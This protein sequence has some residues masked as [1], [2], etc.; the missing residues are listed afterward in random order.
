MLQLSLLA[1]LEKVKM[2]S[3]YNL[4]WN[5][6]H[7]ETFRSFETLR[8]REMFVDVTLS[9][10]DQFLKA[11][12]LVLCAGSGYFERILNRDASG[13]PL[14]HFYGIDM[15]LLKLLVEFMYNGEVEVPS[16]DLEK[17]IE[18]AEHL[19]VKG[20]KGD[21]SKGSSV[22]HGMGG[23]TI[24]VAGVEDA[25]AHKRKSSARSWQDYDESLTPPVKLARPLVHPARQQWVGHTPSHQRAKP[26]NVSCS[27]A[28]C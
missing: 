7:V 22:S 12:K 16:L 6:H 24:P 15:H 11:H 5:S 13:S 18:V 23:T 8:H 9:C 26:I 2:T 20:L 27:L 4:K 25:L 28:G 3:K 17:F 10:N 19:E 21:K 14:I 1:I